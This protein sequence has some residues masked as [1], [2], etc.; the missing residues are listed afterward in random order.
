VRSEVSRETIMELWRFWNAD[1][2]RPLWRRLRVNAIFT[3]RSNFLAYVEQRYG[4]SARATLQAE[5]E[6]TLSERLGYWLYRSMRF[7]DGKACGEMLE[8][9]RAR[10]NATNVA[11]KAIRHVA[12]GLLRRLS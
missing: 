2:T 1:G 4:P 11:G 3:D 10:R 7:L 12:G 8:I 5:L 6:T 9:A